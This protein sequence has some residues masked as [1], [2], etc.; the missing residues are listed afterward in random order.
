MQEA[1]GAYPVIV[2][3]LIRQ[4]KSKEIKVK[5]GVM[6]TFSVLAYIN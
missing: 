4:L 3:N 6:K 1:E 5:V 2:R